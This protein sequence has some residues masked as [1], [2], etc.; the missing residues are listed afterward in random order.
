[1]RSMPASP[2][3]NC[4]WATP[5]LTWVELP[6]Q[7]HKQ[8]QLSWHTVDQDSQPANG[9]GQNYSVGEWLWV[10]SISEMERLC[11]LS[12]TTP[13]FWVN[14]LELVVSPTQRFKKKQLA[15]CMLGA[16]SQEVSDSLKLEYSSSQTVYE[17]RR[18]IQPSNN[19]WSNFGQWLFFV[20]VARY[21]IQHCTKYS[22]ST[23]QE[24]LKKKRSSLW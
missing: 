17:Q 13:L 21:I 10:T 23:M 20:I 24:K 18:Y 6:S 14:H 19:G 1:M 7:T 11:L 5:K 2:N 15:Q 9:N 22:S 4:N 12:K 16:P 8:T 3:C